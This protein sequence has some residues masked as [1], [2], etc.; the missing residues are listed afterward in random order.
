[1]CCVAPERVMTRVYY[2]I[3][4][5]Q[6]HSKLIKDAVQNSLQ[7]TR[8]IAPYTRVIARSGATPHLHEQVLAMLTEL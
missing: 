8:V 7:H 3:T 1:M 2:P 6:A 4:A 5:A